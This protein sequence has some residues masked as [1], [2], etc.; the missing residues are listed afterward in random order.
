[1]SGL[2]LQ[3]WGY[4][5]ESLLMLRKLLLQHLR[6]AK[7]FVTGSSSYACH[8]SYF[9]FGRLSNV[10]PSISTFSFDGVSVS[11]SNAIGL[12]AATA[13][14]KDHGDF[15]FPKA[16]FSICHPA[17]KSIKKENVGTNFSV[18]FGENSLT[19]VDISS[20]HTRPFRHISL[21]KDF[22]FPPGYEV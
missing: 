3:R 19:E 22:P 11:P 5:R 4:G 12:P 20:C 18:R 21:L 1:M 7:A 6:I 8:L 14:R 2:F 15:V 17:F 16:R 9:T 10:N 13:S